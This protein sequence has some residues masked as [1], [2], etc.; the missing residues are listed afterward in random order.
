MNTPEQSGPSAARRQQHGFESWL[1]QA[2]H[3]A[4][5]PRW[6]S[7]GALVMAF[8]LLLVFHQVVS[9]AV[10]QAKLRHQALAT[11]HDSDWRC[12]PGRGLGDRTACVEHAVLPQPRATAQAAQRVKD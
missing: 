7:I 6:Q 9:G 2:T 3:L 4:A 11:Q 1:R 5:Q 10:E 12:K 8:V